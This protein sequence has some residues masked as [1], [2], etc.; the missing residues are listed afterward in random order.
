MSEFYDEYTD[1]EDTNING[2][3]DT[4]KNIISTDTLNLE[5]VMHDLQQKME[6]LS[7]TEQSTSKKNNDEKNSLSSNTKTNT[8]T[9]PKSNETPKNIECVS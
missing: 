6:K 8:N 3:F 1:D 4:I 5:N 2:S 7:N 9:K